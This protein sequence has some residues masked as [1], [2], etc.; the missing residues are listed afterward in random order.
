MGND[1]ARDHISA[2]FAD[3]EKVTE[4]LAR[5]VREA[6]IQ[7]K[8]AGKPIVVWKDGEIVWIP[9]EEIPIDDENSPESGK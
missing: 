7:H 1:A 2:F 6:L 5:G 8:R 9:P 4:A 3:R